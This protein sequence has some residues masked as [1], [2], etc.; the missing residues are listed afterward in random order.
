MAAGAEAAPDIIYARGVSVDPSPDPASFDRKDYS[1]VIFKIGFCRDLGCQ[2]KLTKK[3]EK[4]HACLCALRRYWGRVDLVCIPIG[5][6]GTTLQDTASDIAT[7][8]AK[9]R[10][11]IYNKGK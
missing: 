4:Y 5:H 8:L 3:T 6:S 9:S 10:P 2:D 11:S 1:L 7:A